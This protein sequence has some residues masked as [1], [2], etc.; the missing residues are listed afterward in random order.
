MNN[1]LGKMFLRRLKTLIAHQLPKKSDKVVFCPL[2]EVQRKAY[3]GFL[4]SE[5]VQNIKYSGQVCDCGKLNK[6]G[7]PAKRGSC[8]YV[9]DSKGRKWREMVFPC[10]QQIQKL[11]NHLANWIPRKCPLVQ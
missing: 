5:M 7:E 8:C 10:I 1:L 6:N 3:Q 2:T 11:S 4:E 9:T